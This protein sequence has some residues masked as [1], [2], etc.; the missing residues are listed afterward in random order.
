MENQTL[1]AAQTTLL[2]QSIVELPFSIEFKTL[3]KN[4]GFTC[5]QELSKYRIEELEQLGG[6]NTLMIHEY[7]GFMVG[8]DLGL[9]IDP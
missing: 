1:T 6:F 9:L 7:G 8:N 2:I 4:L 3:M 5:L